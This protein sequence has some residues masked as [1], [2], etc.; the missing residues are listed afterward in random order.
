[1]KTIKYIFLIAVMSVVAFSCKDEALDPLRIN[2]V[3]KG[4][5]LALRGKQLD[6]IYVK[7]KPGAELF[8]KIATGAEKFEFDAE[9][10]SDDKSSLESMDVYVI[11]RPVRTKVLLANIPFSQFKDDGTYRNPWVSVSFTVGEVLA[12]VLPAAPTFPLSAADINVLLTTYTN[13]IRLEIDLNKTDGTQVMATDLVSAGLF[14]SDQFYPAQLLSYA[15]T[16][17]CAYTTAGW[18]GDYD[19]TVIHG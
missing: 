13:G 1:M 12:K 10:L 14:Q 5:I 7:G 2:D 6:N 3:K 16:D 9:Y 15:M 18:S 11:T 8:P 4:T 19:A 17:Y